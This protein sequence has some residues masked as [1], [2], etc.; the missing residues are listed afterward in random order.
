M[1]EDLNILI[2]DDNIG[3][4]DDLSKG[5]KEIG[6]SVSAVATGEEAVECVENNPQKFDFVLIDHVLKNRTLSD[7]DDQNKLD[8]I[9]TCR[10]IY[11]RT[12]EIINVIYSNI[13]TDLPQTIEKFKKKAYK[14]GA[15]R[16]MRREGNAH[17]Q[18]QD[19]IN[20]ISVLKAIRDQLEKIHAFQ[21]EVPSLIN[22]INIGVMLIDKEYKI[23]YM[24]PKMKDILGM[25][26]NDSNQLCHVG[27]HDFQDI[28][29]GCHFKLL[30]SNKNAK[31]DIRLR[32]IKGHDGELKY[33]NIGC[34]AVV[35]KNKVI[36]MIK[37]TYDITATDILKNMK[38]KQRLEIIS[39]SLKEH[40][41]GFDHGSIYVNDANENN[42]YH[43]L[44][45]WGHPEQFVGKITRD[46]NDST[47]AKDAI[48]QYKNSKEGIFKK[49]NSFFEKH[50]QEAV[51]GP[52][53]VWPI[54][55]KDQCLSILDLFGY[56]NK[57][58]TWDKKN[59]VK[60][61]ADEIRKAILD[62]QIRR[63][64][65]PEIDAII[66]ELDNAIIKADSCEEVIK[67]LL[68]KALK[69][70]NSQSIH[71]R[72]RENNKAILLPIY[73]G[74]YPKLA[75]PVYSIFKKEYISCRV[76]LSQNEYIKPNIEKAEILA[77][78]RQ[79]R[80]ESQRNALKPY[81]S[82]CFVPMIFMGNCIGTIGLHSEKKGNYD[83]KKM[84]VI[85]AIAKK[86]AVALHDYLIKQKE[87]QAETLKK[88]AEFVTMLTHDLKTPL[89]FM[90]KASEYLSRAV[91]HKD[92]KALA[93]SINQNSIRLNYSVQKL[94]SYG[95]I[96]TGDL[97]F[98]KSKFPLEEAVLES[99]DLMQM[100]AKEAK[101]EIIYNIEALKGDAFVWGDKYLMIE[102]FNNLIENAIKFT[103]NVGNKIHIQIS[104]EDAYYKTTIKDNG[105]GIHADLKPYVFDKFF[106]DD[107]HTPGSPGTG[108]GIGLAVV[109]YIIEGHD[110]EVWV[111]SNIDKGSKF[112]FKLPKMSCTN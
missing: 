80:S 81:K 28:C 23:W 36:A 54:M 108:T 27:L 77:K 64:M 55:E 72:Y 44:G 66:A 92:H 13:P 50:E 43:L 65:Y 18:I 49:E 19:F 26:A 96:E 67:I 103:R 95:Q 15:V 39:K 89:S 10:K 31:D 25:N 111:E 24:S 105:V 48:E 88:K 63:E 86:I 42:L 70:T 61:Y 1:N 109:K 35:H 83:D 87:V 100:A 79:K 107:P 46:I 8:G 104:N 34:Q 6:Y 22:Y 33:F 91:D 52:I 106:H 74:E 38:I 32:P 59:I 57:K 69:H 41:R 7:T 82:L 58:C 62:S 14:A 47:Y 17:I 51:E 99:V 98:N 76:M 29:E 85:R 60:L 30:S 78:F 3:T 40:E 84:D 37:S 73:I 90:I 102:V 12:K 5:L 16:Y 75:T 56:E 71:I 94:L 45:A 9:E 21:S 97:K 4:R 101:L 20:E 93:V 110:G 11:G 2:V 68:E 53:I 112:S